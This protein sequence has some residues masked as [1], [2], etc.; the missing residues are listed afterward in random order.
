MTQLTCPLDFSKPA[1]REAVSPVASPRRAFTRCYRIGPVEVELTSRV[2]GVLDAYHALCAPYLTERVSSSAFRVEVAAR[3][4]PRTGLRHYHILANGREEFTV[5]RKRQ[6]LSHVE[7]A[8]NLMV[9][10]HL[11]NLLAIHAACVARG[12]VAM[13]MPGAPGSG[14][15]TTTA[16]LLRRG[17]SYYSDEFALIDPDSLLLEAYPKAMSIKSG[18]FELLRHRLPPLEHITAHERRT[19]GFLRC[20]P[21]RLIRE[22]VV[23]SPMRPGLIVFPTY[24]VGASTELEP[25]SRARAVFEMTRQCFNLFKFRRRAV[26][27]LAEVVSRAECYRLVGSDLDD[28]CDA[29]EDLAEF[30]EPMR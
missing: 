25:M 5:R 12:H 22:N 16:E 15:T 4:S 29:I 23:A 18:A 24:Q 10:R 8:L 30:R 26:D 19:K 21:P 9:A 1:S 11:P 3:R 20:L 27:I 14:K 17:W 28:M 6:V 13:M 2:S 7:G